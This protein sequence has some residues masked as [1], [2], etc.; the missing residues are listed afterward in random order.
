M[1]GG[2]RPTDHDQVQRV[3]EHI[4]SLARVAAACF[5]SERS[6]PQALLHAQLDSCVDQLA[7]PVASEVLELLQ[8]ERDEAVASQARVDCAVSSAR[9]NLP[10]QPSPLTAPPSPSSQPR[11]K[12]F[13][14]HAMACLL[15]RK[16]NGGRGP[17]GA[18]SCEKG[19]RAGGAHVDRPL[20]LFPPPSHTNPRPT[21]TLRPPLLARRQQRQARAV[22]PPPPHIH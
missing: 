20:P 13:I 12:A 21:Q 17:A 9:F 5:G 18:V 7:G 14:D 11:A 4:R 2:A 16:L 1:R 3:A 6:E 10:H 8:R 15:N 22:R 19:G